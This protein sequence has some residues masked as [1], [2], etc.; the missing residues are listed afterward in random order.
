MS[1]QVI[2][3]PPIL[4]PI[5]VGFGWD[6]VMPVPISAWQMFCHTEVGVQCCVIMG[7]PATLHATTISSSILRI[8]VCPWQVLPQPVMHA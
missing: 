4:T 1:V 2:I 6:S 5:L 3:T 8:T 7:V